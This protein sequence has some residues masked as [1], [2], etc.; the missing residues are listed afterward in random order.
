MDL[1]NQKFVV[2]GEEHYNPLGIIRS[3]GENGI[4]CDA[5]II[6]HRQRVASASKY[7][8]R[9]HMVDTIEDGYALLL[10]EYANPDSKVFV[11]AGDDKVTSFLDMRYDEIKDLFYFYNAGQ[12]GRI[13]YFMDKNHINILARKHGLNVA[14][15][16]V[17]NCGQVPEGLE[18]PVITK[19]ISSNSGAWKDDVFVCHSRQELEE[20]YKKI[21][22]P[23]VLLQKY[24][25]KKNELCIDGFTTNRGQEMFLSMAATYDYI[26]PDQYSCYMTITNIHDE[27]LYSRIKAMLTE[28]GYEGI[29][30]IE[31]LIGE[32]DQ[33]YFLEVNMRN[34]GWSYASTCAGMNLPMLWCE[35]ML[36]RQIPAHSYK[37]IPE[38][39]KAIVEV[40][41]FKTRVLGRKIGL[42]QW[43]RELKRCKC[44]FYWSSADPK[45]FWSAIFSKF[46][47]TINK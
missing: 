36:T 6:R 23:V 38:G 46:F 35:S 43:I 19:A 3:L 20:A 5:I 18:Y 37:E 32:D 9:L 30:C 24:I 10:K 28:L 31:F 8:A 34:S 7:I 33:L 16:H 25:K 44:T 22:S 39:F 26:L 29:F 4:F 2:F 14:K 12:A 41:D 15:T 13:T 21:Q 11:L 40:T 27:P 1:K 42:F 47:K 45:P 17:V